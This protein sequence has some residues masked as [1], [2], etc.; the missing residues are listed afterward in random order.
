MTTAYLRDTADQAGLRTS[1]LAIEALGWDE[2]T[3]R[4][5]DLDGGPV[6][7]LFKLYPWEWL[8]EEE[9]GRHLAPSAGSTLWIEPA[10]KMI[11]SSKGILPILW[12]LSPRHPNLLE[13]HLGGPG[14]L[15][16]YVRKPLLSRE[17]ANITL[18]SAGRRPEQSEDAGYGGEGY[19][20]QD[21]S[22]LPSFEGR[23]PVIGSW[24]IGGEAAGIGV[25]ESDGAITDNRSRFV[26]H[27]F[28]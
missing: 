17:G 9:F 25:R 20:F 23:R 7:S 10:W 3:R 22:P 21:L 16:Q 8:L 18:V 15:R 13:S 6:A 5:V 14:A 4:F 19:V 28:E 26:P 24:V 2:G 1:Q 27:L 11:L 12:E